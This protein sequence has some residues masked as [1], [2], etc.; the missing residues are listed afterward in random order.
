MIIEVERQQISDEIWYQN[1][2]GPND[3]T[4]VDTWDR[5]A[6][7]CSSIENP[8]IKQSIYEDF[9][10]LLD[11]FKG[12]A[13]GR[14]TANLGIDGRES[15]TMMNCFVHSPGD[16]GYND[17]DSI[18][19]IYDML[20][21]QAHTLKSEGG[22]GMNFSWIRPNGTYIEGIDSRTPGV[23]SFMELWDTSSK[24][25]TQGSEK[26]IGAKRPNEKR[27]IR[28]GAQMGILECVAGDTL[29]STLQGIFKIKDLVGK[30]P[31][32]HCT[33]GNGNLYIK[34]TNKVWKTGTR[35]VIKIKFD[36]DDYLVCTPEHEI[37]LSDGTYRQAKDLKIG[38]SLSALKDAK[39]SI[40]VV[41]SV[42]EF[43][44]EDVYDI[45]V[46]EFHNFVANGIFVHNCWHPEIEDFID[47][48][49]VDGRLSKFNLSV[50]IT[51]GFVNAVLND[52][53][54]I[55][56]FPDP[57]HPEFNTWHGDIYNWESR[58][59]PVIVYKSIKARQL[60]SKIVKS[61]YTRN[62][63]GVLFLDLVNKRNP[64]YYA[65]RIVTSNPCFH[66]DE[67]FLT[68]N[69]YVKFIDSAE[70]GWCS[71]VTDNR[72]SYVDDGISEKPENWK[73]NT[74]KEGTTL[75]D[76][77][78]AFIT[79]EYS[80][81]LKLEFSN[82]QT[83]RCTPDHHF[84][85]KYGM[86]EAKDLTPDHDILVPAP[87]VDF[88]NSIIG[89]KPLSKDDILSFLM[90]LITSSG[91]IDNRYCH[92]DIHNDNYMVSLIEKIL[93]TQ[94]IKYVKNYNEK[95]QKVRITS[96]QLVTLLGKYCYPLRITK[97][98]VPEDIINK[99]KTSNGLFY[100][101]GLYYGKGS[102]SGNSSY[103]IC[104]RLT[105]DSKKLLRQV[106]LLLHAN[107]ILST[108]YSNNDKYEL[109][110]TGGY[111]KVF[112]KMIPF[113]YRE[114]DDKIQDFL[115]IFNEH[116]RKEVYTNLISSKEIEGDTVYCI[117]EP[118][119][120]SIIVNTCSVR[121]CGEILMPTGVCLLFSLN[122]VKYIKKVNDRFEFDFE[123]FKKAV[124]IA[125]RFADNIN[126]ISKVPLPEYKEAMINKRRIGIGVLALGSL[127]Y[128][129]GIRFGSEESQKLIYEIFKV[130]AETE[131]LAS[132]R[133]GKEKGS[134]PLFDRDKYFNSYW[135]KTLPIS[136][137]VKR[138]VEEIGEMR[139]SHRSANAPTG[140]MSLYVGVVSGGI[141]PVFMKEYSR[142]SIVTEEERARLRSIGFKFPDV[143]SGQ[144]FE[145][146][147]LKA[148]KA[149][150]DDILIGSFE[151]KSYQIDKNRGLTVKTDVVD[152]GWQFVQNN[153]TEDQIKQMEND[154]VFCTTSDLSVQDHINS[155]KMISPFVDQNSSKTINIPSDYSFDD[156]ENVYLD[157][158]K[159]GI[160]GITT[161]RA[162]TMTAVLEGKKD[163]LKEIRST[164]KRPKELSCE[165]HRPKIN[166]KEWGVLVGI[167]N[168]EPYEIFAGPL[169]N[170]NFPGKG[171]GFLRR[172]K[173]GVYSLI[174]NDVEID[175]IIDYFSDDESAWA[176]RMIS[177]CLRHKI[178][179]KF[180]HEQ[181][182]KDG[183][184]TDVN[185]VLARI[186]NKYIKSSEKP[187]CPNCGSERIVL[188]EG[189]MSC[190]DCTYGKCG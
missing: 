137:D 135:W 175:N 140:N 127:H 86:V 5:Q 24:I 94:K 66:G 110:T 55:L 46:P 53:E 178:P 167:Y 40:I 155:L 128:I 59:L 111:W 188:G 177:M 69:G 77:S 102:V 74:F 189:C 165:I 89:K 9:K 185:N 144:W 109:V 116:Y 158:W 130:K 183:Y 124:S 138:E 36:N 145:T 2:Q 113:F 87:T 51:E 21:A 149:G 80:D 104:V 117:K 148:S 88:G 136:D 90:G 30:N 147:F 22:Y 84:A 7:T 63:P 95:Y 57:T 176:T 68:R 151:G 181:L 14:I 28:K 169:S 29:I 38:D 50:G 67:R 17:P 100:L 81:L 78:S 96:S 150:T 103:N 15:V 33:D 10:W 61:T 141:E 64:L 163:N 71:V 25:V 154:G 156:F 18:E 168:D 27:K 42:E 118:E 99:A 101:S 123:T 129:L 107:G 112:G 126:D 11:D 4:L 76:S 47:A 35:D 1:Y 43:G 143:A 121:R 3:N 44:T 114:K 49:L 186:L 157:A 97:N 91:F 180:I 134:F 12:V 45:S 132:A 6:K 179:L 62:D 161:Y 70:N 142:W 20:K 160:K 83:I 23:L 98:I 122:L 41:V 164:D 173:Q 182:S 184:I 108:I 139:N 54:W 106:Q 115:K 125:V 60:W 133:L 187:K 26:I 79:K 171:S 48:K 58:N 72:I 52:D 85:T 166:G 105:N 190:L 93:Y 119:T 73:I 170:K 152:F 13:G 75:R 92:I 174:V 19:G 172:K 131:I 146:D 37:M 120:R 82:G 56:R 8:D 16:I 159:A 39:L 162:G 31:S 65:E 153:Y 32:V 34:E